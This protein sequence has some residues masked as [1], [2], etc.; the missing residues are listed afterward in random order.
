MQSIRNVVLAF[1]VFIY[2][3][4]LCQ[5]SDSLVI[6]INDNATLEPLPKATLTEV[7]SGVVIPSSADGR[8]RIPIVGHARQF[9]ITHVGYNSKVVQIESGRSVQLI[10]DLESAH[11]IIEEV[12]VSTG[13]QTLPRE[14]A[15]GSFEALDAATIARATGYDILSRMEGLTASTLIAKNSYNPNQYTPR[16]LTASQIRIRGESSLF[17][18]ANPL[19]ILDNFPYDG[20]ISS[21]NPNDV[22]NITLLK[23]AAAASIWG[24][25]AGNGVIV[26][27]TKK[28]SYNQP[29]RIS[30]SATAGTYEKPD[31]YYLRGLPASDF[32]DVEQFLFGHGFYNSMENN[33]RRP[34]L[35]PAVEVFIQH[36][37]GV[38]NDEQLASQLQEL[39][40]NDVRKDYLDHVYRHPVQ[41]QYAVSI[42]GGGDSFNFRSSFGYDSHRQSLDGNSDSRMSFRNEMTYRPI[43]KLSIQASIQYVQRMANTQDR[44]GYGQISMGNYDLYPYARL[45]NE[46]GTAASIAKDYR[47]GFVDT[48]GAGLLLDWHYRPLEDL[49]D[50][51]LQN[52]DVMLQGGVSYTFVPGLSLDLKYQYQNGKADLNAVNG[53]EKYAVR[54]KINRF[55]EINGHQL[56]R[57]FPLGAELL[58]GIDRLISHNAR[59][60]LNFNQL[61]GRHEVAGLGGVEVRQRNSYGQRYTLYGFD[62]ETLNFS[63]VDAINRYPLYGNLGSTALLPLATESIS[64]LTNRYVSAFGNAGYTYDGR[65]T[66]SASV[67]KDASNL[68][69]VETNQRWQPLWSVGAAWIVSNERNIRTGIFNHLKARVTYGYSGNIDP[70]RS[71]HTIIAHRPLEN[72]TG[73]SYADIMNPPDPS[74]RWERVSTLNAGVDFSAYQSRVSGTLEVYWKRSIDLFGITPMDWTTG[75]RSLTTNSAHTRGDGIDATIRSVNIEYGNFKWQTIATYS[76]NRTKLLEYLGPERMASSYI[77]PSL[78]KTILPDYPLYA[79]FSY[80]WAGLDPANGNPQ[81]WLDG[82]VSMDYNAIR[83][84]TTFD[85]LVL[86]GSGMPVHFGGLR[87]DVS[88]G[89]I[90]LS[91]NIT[92][93]LAYFFR[94]EGLR[95]SSLFSNYRHHE[96]WQRRWV[97]SGDEIFTDVPSM[98][99]PASSTRDD[100]Y[101]NSEVMVEKG[102]HVRL[103]DL[104]L[105]YALNNIRIQK[106]QVRAIQ[107]FIYANNLGILWRANNKG[108]DPDN[109]RNIPPPKFYNLGFSLNF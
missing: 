14:R 57:H 66:V 101:A 88:Y 32:I 37:D 81:G 13:Y 10:V 87:N 58:T 80:R 65:Y 69:G 67:R 61:W 95:Y 34:A 51:A 54:N 1:L 38:L 89:P 64:D 30:F 103:Q 105:G 99:Y 27:T 76:H 59:A 17:T 84:N 23:D 106:Y 97:Q 85:D 94:R 9:A 4:V 7:G 100:F 104:R 72:L 21:I 109:I 44:D 92:Y 90:S 29:L 33:I 24:A 73:R 12:A 83:R 60:Q 26:I 11:S 28:G 40:S 71:A 98:I 31:L 50:R 45:V 2:S 47:L 68:L 79:V 91:M 22:E 3:P 82:T 75:F 35:S 5:I 15:T 41:Q 53:L 56:T 86:H 102:D 93:R 77:G 63:K 74:L 42:G 16:S 70:S 78:S 96:D 25:Q 48:A 20:D 55:T 19:I 108:I 36:R 43:D 39:G 49:G 107:V 52:Q 46:D 8:F 62:P 18:E 6:V